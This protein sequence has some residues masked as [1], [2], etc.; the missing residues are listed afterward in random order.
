MDK[1]VKKSILGT[2]GS[3]KMSKEAIAKPET[4]DVGH[5][6]QFVPPSAGSNPLTES[7]AEA[8]RKFYE[9]RAKYEPV[10]RE[11]YEKLQRRAESKRRRA[12]A[13]RKAF[14]DLCEMTDGMAAFCRRNNVSLAEGAEMLNEFRPAPYAAALVARFQ[15]VW[16]G[17]AARGHE[18]LLL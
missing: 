18:A 12:K 15:V 5:S 9:W 2:G 17:V 10:E 13:R 7:E 1:R 14:G 11:I 6:F 4:L 8:K 16:I 3:K